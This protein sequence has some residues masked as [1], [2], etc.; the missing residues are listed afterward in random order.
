MP[1]P[2]GIHNLV[3]LLD[4][5]AARR[6]SGIALRER[7]IHTTIE[8]TYATWRVRTYQ[9]ADW[10]REVGI[11]PGEPVALL[12]P[13][14]R[15][16]GTAFLAVLANDATVVPLDVRATAR[17][18]A[19]IIRAAG[20][21][22]LICADTCRALVAALAEHAV[23]I[24]RL[25]WVELAEDSSFA[26]M[27]ATRTLSVLPRRALRH[28]PAVII[29]T[30]G[31]TGDP[32]GVVLSHGNILIDVY[33]LLAML[34]ISSHESF[35]SILPLNHAYELTGG[36]VAPLA[37]AATITYV[38]ALRPDIILAALHEA[39]MSVM[40]VVPA[41]LRLFMERIRAEG[42][43]RL[44]R[45]FTVLHRLCYVAARLRMPL[46]RLLFWPV[47]RMISPAFKCFICGGAPVDPHLLWDFEALGLTVLQGYGLTETAP[48]ISVN[49]LRANRI[50]SVGRPVA[51]VDLRIVPCEGARPGT[52]ELWVR[53]SI[54][55]REYYRNPHATA[56]AFHLD[57]F[58]TGD[59]VARDRR[60]FLYVV[61]RIKNIIVTEGGKNIYPEELEYAFAGLPGVKEFCIVG[62]R[63]PGAGERPVAVLVPDR[64]ALA[65]THGADHTA[66]DHALKRAFAAR[67]AQLA[68]YQ[69]PKAVI[70]REDV[71][72][73]ATLKIKRS[74]LREELER[75]VRH[76]LQ[77]QRL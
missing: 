20:V 14:G 56:L 5:A 77:D 63:E 39:R 13:N 35:V 60:G 9:F 32:K 16:W 48:V 37:L 4:A 54:V 31:T 67:A 21:R 2:H 75:A 41:F 55:F 38:S 72:K 11:T 18:I 58:K 73:T 66:Q 46:G 3:D 28:Y 74:A 47:R 42:R 62:V 40:M 49:T 34:E 12:L 19:S 59:L 25:L 30:S 8:W 45:L 70:I 7:G 65:R 51:S 33:D 15:W 6:P 68:D 26:V 50:G 17:D 10:L 44:G 52:G 76:S 69:R 64:E 24:E 27:L 22:T 61:G 43:R 57:W 53:G 1:I 29:Y 23:H 36:F 71:P